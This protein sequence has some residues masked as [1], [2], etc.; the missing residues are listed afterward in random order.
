MK[1]YKHEPPVKAKEIQTQKPSSSLV[2]MDP[3]A[4]ILSKDPVA[5]DEYYG[6]LEKKNSSKRAYDQY[7]CR[8][9]SKIDNYEDARRYTKC[10]LLERDGFK[11]K[12]RSLVEE[13]E[14]L[15][16]RWESSGVE[17]D[18]KLMEELEQL[19]KRAHGEFASMKIPL[20]CHDS[21][22]YKG[23]SVDRRRLIKYLQ[24]NAI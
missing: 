21:H 16:Q 5:L 23:M 1:T 4:G 8:V 18:E 11:D 15:I 9:A 24:D 10:I 22:H 14:Q 20:F 3:I 2:H 13:Q 6:L 17:D 12:I 19:S 7:V